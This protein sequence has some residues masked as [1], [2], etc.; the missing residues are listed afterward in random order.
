[1]LAAFIGRRTDW[2]WDQWATWQHPEREWAIA[3]LRKWIQPDDEH[4][5]CLEAEE[6]P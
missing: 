3:E 1:M 4:P 2:C 6:L 5:V